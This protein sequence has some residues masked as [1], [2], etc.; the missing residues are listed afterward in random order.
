MKKVYF[1]ALF[2]ILISFF[3]SIYFYPKVPDKIAS[4]W[5]INGNVN[6]FMGKFLGL[7]L[8][9]FI[10]VF[11]F[12]LFYFIPKIDPLKKNIDDFVNYIWGFIILI[13]LFFLILQLQVI[14]WNL[15]VEIPFGKT[16]SILSGVLFFYTGILLENSKRNWF[17]GIRTPWTLSS[18]KVWKKTHKFGGKLFKI[19]GIISILGFLFQ[20][21]VFY[22]I[23]FPVILTAVITFFYSYFA[24]KR[25]R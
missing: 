19:S 16:L 21:Y 8:F 22:M 4:H 25:K 11:L 5:D 1:F 15:G 24:Y 23:I 2:I 6:G 14:L 10:A 3:L 7:F 9:P 18:E 13:L 12:L 17:I 20:K